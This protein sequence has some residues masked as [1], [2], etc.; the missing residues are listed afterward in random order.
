MLEAEAAALAAERRTSADLDHL[1]EVCERMEEAEANR[2]E[3]FRD[4]MANRNHEFHLGILE[5]ARS[6]RLFNICK[7]LTMAPLMS[8]SFHAYD[9]PNLHRSLSDH[10][11][12]LTSI[13]LQDAESA[14]AMM[15]AH[16]RITYQFMSKPVRQT[17]IA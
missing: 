13:T 7:N 11:A 10:R 4:V 8:G 15:A 16:L 5:V 3:G 1:V 14:R 6:P 12:I 17:L 9:D 2:E